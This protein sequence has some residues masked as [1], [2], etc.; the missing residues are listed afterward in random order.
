MVAFARVFVL[1]A[2]VGMAV[3]HSAAVEAASINS[4]PETD[5]HFLW[6]AIGPQGVEV[7]LLGSIHALP[8]DA[9]P[10]PDVMEQAFRQARI[11]AFEVDLEEIDRAAGLMFAAAALPAGRRLA[12]ELE[13][14]TRVELEEYLSQAGLSF[15]TF[16]A[17]RPWMVALTLTTLELMKAGYSPDAGIDFHFARRV[18]E[19]D[20]KSIAF[21]NAAFQIGLFS[22]MSKEEEA[23]FLRYSLRD[24]RTII[25]QLKELTDAWKSGDVEVIG[26]LLT[27]AFADEDELFG[28]LVTERNE[29]WLPRVEELL[30]GDQRALVVVGALHLVGSGGLVALL[31]E[32]GYE[33]EQL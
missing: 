13:P 17:M 25:P 15:E 5:R 6:R 11:V 7:F 21:E 28:R 8:Q 3:V 32:A 26:N 29:A 16:T 18:V 22:Q 31:Q 23:A 20:K 27:E 19:E 1:T 30:G 14:E 4:K 33:V 9:Y 12:E 10:L 24:L 2:V